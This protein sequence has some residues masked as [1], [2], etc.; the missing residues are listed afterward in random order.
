MHGLQ[1]V[2]S[3][4]LLF[5]YAAILYQKMTAPLFCIFRSSFLPGLTGSVFE[6]IRSMRASPS[7][8]A[9]T[10]TRR[11]KFRHSKTA[12]EMFTAYLYMPPLSVTSTLPATAMEKLYILYFIMDRCGS[13]IIIA[14]CREITSFRLLRLL[15]D[16]GRI[17][18][19]EDKVTC[20]LGEEFHFLKFRV[21]RDYL[22][23]QKENRRKTGR[24]RRAWNSRFLPL[25]PARPVFMADS[26][27]VN[28]LA[29]YR[30]AGSSLAAGS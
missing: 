15:A 5:P 28:S 21:S 14:K 7:G 20:S 18:I 22:K 3:G 8:G 9:W 12:M 6:A 13:R 17:E 23:R 24:S 2:P 16:R 30:K 10:S 19:L 1:A 27:A 11:K 25:L 4:C 29:A 26:K